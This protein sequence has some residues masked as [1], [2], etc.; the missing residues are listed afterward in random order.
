MRQRTLIVRFRLLKMGNT[1]NC[2]LVPIS[3]MDLEWAIKF[4]SSPSL[5]GAVVLTVELMNT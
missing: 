5:I 4:I 2:G 1:L 3:S